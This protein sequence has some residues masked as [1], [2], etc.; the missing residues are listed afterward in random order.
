MTSDTLARVRGAITGIVAVAQFARS[1]W[2]DDA[3]AIEA[4]YAVADYDAETIGGAPVAPAFMEGPGDWRPAFRADQAWRELGQAAPMTVDYRPAGP[5]T[6]E[7]AVTVMIR[8]EEGEGPLVLTIGCDARRGLCADALT[9]EALGGDPAGAGVDDGEGAEPPLA[10][11]AGAGVES[12]ECERVRA[13]LEEVARSHPAA[14][15]W[16]E[17]GAARGPWLP[18]DGRAATAARSGLAAASGRR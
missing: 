14:V 8:A 13:A 17:E 7:L 10:S 6:A 2:I 5:G 11:L 4:G 18:A 15:I 12:G 1:E 3:E 16:R 9:I